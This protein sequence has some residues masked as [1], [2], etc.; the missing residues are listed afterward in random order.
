MRL[1]KVS[2]TLLVVFTLAIAAF[3]Q[4]ATSS[5]RG[6]VADPKGAVIP[7]ATVKL[8][9]PSTGY[10]RTVTT[11]DSGEY[12]FLQVKPG[13]YDVSAVAKDMGSA[14]QKGVQLL[15]S[16]PST[17]DFTMKPSSTTV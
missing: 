6:T 16:Q 4:T 2:L 1:L 13:R 7:G 15:V 14:T 17:L 8:N 5:L 12:Q 11:N 10:S 3:A 9:S